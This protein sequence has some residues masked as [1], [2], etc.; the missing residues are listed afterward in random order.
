MYNVHGQARAQHPIAE[1]PSAAP[2]DTYSL[3]RRVSSNAA[4]G[5]GEERED[6]TWDPPDTRARRL[7]SAKCAGSYEIGKIDVL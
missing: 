5:A 4:G 2:A 1:H 7:V 6:Q 3:A